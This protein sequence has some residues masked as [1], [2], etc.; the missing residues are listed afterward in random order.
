[1]EKKYKLKKL[2]IEKA[3]YFEIKRKE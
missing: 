3:D 1:M 2:M